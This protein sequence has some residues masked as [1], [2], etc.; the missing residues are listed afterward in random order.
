MLLHPLIRLLPTGSGSPPKMLEFLMR[1]FAKKEQ[2]RRLLFEL[3]GAM[4]R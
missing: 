4:L 3:V 2:A 1:E